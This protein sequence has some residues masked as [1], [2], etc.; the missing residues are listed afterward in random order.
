MEQF[1]PQFYCRFDEISSL[2]QCA[3]EN[4]FVLLIPTFEKAQNELS[5]FLQLKYYFMAVN[6]QFHL[7]RITTADQKYLLSF[8]I[9]HAQVQGQSYHSHGWEWKLMFIVYLWTQAKLGYYCIE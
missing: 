2:V 3:K 8:I 1:Q 4:E 6:A 7:G 5:E 9:I